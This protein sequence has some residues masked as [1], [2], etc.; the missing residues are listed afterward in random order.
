MLYLVTDDFGKSAFVNAPFLAHTDRL[1]LSAD[2]IMEVE[3]S[4]V[5]KHSSCGHYFTSNVPV[6][7]PIY[8]RT[9]VGVSLVGKTKT[10][11]HVGYSAVNGFCIP[12]RKVL[13]NYDITV[14]KVV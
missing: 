10:Q 12:N 7:N 13:A 1:Y 4:K 8:G 11:W 9:K 3:T 6:A 14:N 5:I 2:A